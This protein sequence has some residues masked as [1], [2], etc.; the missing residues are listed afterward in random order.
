MNEA[1]ASTLDDWLTLVATELDCTT[2]GIILDDLLAV[3]RDVAHNQIRPGAPTSTFYIGYALGLWE[4][5][6]MDAGEA[7]SAQA[8]AEKLAK[9]CTLVQHLA[10]QPA[11]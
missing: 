11:V 7:P 10:A 2:E 3:A 9:L 8:R 1:E 6:L 5:T 4:Q